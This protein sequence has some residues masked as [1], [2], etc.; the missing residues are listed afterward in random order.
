VRTGAPQKGEDGF[1][2]EAAVLV[3][4]LMGA[5]YGVYHIDGIRWNDIHI[6]INDDQFRYSRNIPRQ[7]RGGYNVGTIDGMDL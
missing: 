4:L 5:I 6:K 2:R 1:V 3:V 7:F